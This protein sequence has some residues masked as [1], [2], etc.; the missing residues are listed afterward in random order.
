[1]NNYDKNLTFGKYK[2]KTLSQIK[3]EDVGYLEWLIKQENTAEGLKY[4]LMKIL[5]NEKLPQRKKKFIKKL[6]IKS[7]E[8]CVFDDTE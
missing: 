3:A 2:G 8:N 5:E 1:M 4:C 6:E 7:P